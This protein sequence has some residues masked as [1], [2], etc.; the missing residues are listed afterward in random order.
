MPKFA[1]IYRNATPPASPEEGQQYMAD[2]RNWSDS[3]GDAL[4]DPGMPFSQT[5]AVSSGD[6]T[7]DIGPQTLNGMS[8]VEVA[9]CHEA[10]AMAERCPHLARGGD[11]VIAEGM[12]MEM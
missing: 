2:W 11:I 10:R 1:F 9:D 6:A 8:V 7:Q 4:I 12:D 5:V 3:L